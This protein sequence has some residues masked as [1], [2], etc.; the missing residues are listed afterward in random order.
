M[1]GRKYYSTKCASAI[2]SVLTGDI[3][4]L[5]ERYFSDLSAAL[6]QRFP[7]EDSDRTWK[8]YN[9]MKNQAD[10]VYVAAFLDLARVVFSEQWGKLTFNATG[11]CKLLELLKQRAKGKPMSYNSYNK[12]PEV[13]VHFAN[14]VVR[15]LQDGNFPS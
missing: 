11:K 9:D 13:A 14:E 6:L 4:G 5:V 1:H 8:K 10:A 15:L 3:E 12:D 2:A 7:K